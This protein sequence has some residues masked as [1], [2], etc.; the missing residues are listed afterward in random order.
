MIMGVVTRL[1]GV[2]FAVE[3]FPEYGY[4]LLSGRKLGDNR[5]GEKVTIDSW[6]RNHAGFSLRKVLVCL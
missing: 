5:A 3:N 2:Q 4:G 6:K 1:K